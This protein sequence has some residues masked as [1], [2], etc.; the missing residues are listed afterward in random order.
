MIDI[1]DV[2]IST[3]YL[4]QNTVT[5][6]NGKISIEEGRGRMVIRD[7]IN[8][9]ELTVVD[10]DGFTFAD[11][12]DRRIRIG[13]SPNNDRVGV[14]VSKPGIDVIDTIN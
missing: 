6:L 3:T 11:S 8:N 9:R 1:N 13:N 5:T 4:G 2:Q 14:W 7:A 12:N 10:D